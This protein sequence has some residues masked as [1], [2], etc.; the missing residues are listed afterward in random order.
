M[1]IRS[2]ITSFISGK[3]EKTSQRPTSV[4]EYLMMA[5]GSPELAAKRQKML[6]ELNQQAENL[7]KKD[8]ATWR[9]AWQ[10][11][12]NYENP[13]RST[14]YDVYTDSLVDLHLT[15]CITQRKGKTLQKS[16]ILS[17][18]NGKENEAARKIFECEW[19]L[20]FIDLALDSAFWG[21]SLIQLG[22]VIKKE[23]TLSFD[24]V[25]LVPRKH[26]IPEY[27]VIVK[28]VGDEWKK[29][30]SYREGE[31]AAWCVEVGAARNL[32]LLLKCAPQSLSK[33]NMLAYWD[34]FGEIFGMPIRIG[35]TMSQDKSDIAR[36]ETMLAEMGAAAWGLFPEGTE[37]EIKETTRGDAFNV[38]DKR[39]DRCNS[40][41]SKGILGQ[42]MTI[43]NGSS[44]SQSETHLE[45]FENIC[46][47]DATLLKY[48]INDQLIPRMIALGFP[49][50]GIIFDWDEAVEHTPAEQREAERLALQ[51]FD[52]DPQ[53]FIDKYKIPI[54]GV[55][56]PDVNSFF[57]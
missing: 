9:Q 32:G 6:I 35:K 46:R 39:V 29:G 20:D 21:H 40:E 17:D 10:R 14:L 34:T 38:Y 45:V 23:D 3:P 28:D 16:F 44:H 13:Q 1:S 22:N 27:G 53:Y 30:L 47:G 36:I 11:A 5:A 8:I 52:I 49:L 51:Y 24:G 50:K 54:T 37:I 41:I 48:I 33:K 19:F 42:T 31:L 43:D 4:E 26:V 12:I 25:E 56:K 55:K 18:K 15:G 57:G 7:T 2:K